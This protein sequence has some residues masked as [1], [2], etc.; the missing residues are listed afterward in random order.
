MAKKTVHISGKKKNLERQLIG[1][2]VE[3]VWWCPVDSVMCQA[4][5]GKIETNLPPF[6]PQCRE[7]RDRKTHGGL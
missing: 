6:Q 7:K 3:S 5:C 1:W 4:G 2:M